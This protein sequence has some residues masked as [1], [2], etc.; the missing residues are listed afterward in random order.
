MVRSVLAQLR[1]WRCRSTVEPTRLYINRKAYH[2]LRHE[3]KYLIG[4]NPDY[5]HDDAG[6]PK[7]VILF[8]LTIYQTDDPERLEV[9]A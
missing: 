9:A 4:D 1:D 7:L 2:L 8:G 3:L 6:F 5:P